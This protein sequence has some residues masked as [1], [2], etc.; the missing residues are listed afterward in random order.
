MSMKNSSDA[1]G[2]RTRDLPNFSAVPQP[3]APPRAPRI[4]CMCNESIL[5]ADLLNADTSYE[6]TDRVPFK[7][8]VRERCIM[9]VWSRLF[10]RLDAFF[11]TKTSPEI[12]LRLITGSSNWRQVFASLYWWQCASSHLSRF[13]NPE[14]WCIFPAA[15]CC[16]SRLCGCLCLTCCRNCRRVPIQESHTSRTSWPYIVQ[17]NTPEWFSAETSRPSRRL[18]L[19]WSHVSR[20]GFQVGFIRLCHNPDMCKYAK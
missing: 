2:N 10:P 3:T 13:M 14:I 12:T 15:F 18:M 17:I 9:P 5:F 19:S 1:I 6:N 20:A 16:C 7:S 4:H 8:R 11:P